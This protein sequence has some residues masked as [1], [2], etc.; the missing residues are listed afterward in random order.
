M[1]MESIFTTGTIPLA[2]AEGGHHGPSYWGLIFYIGLALLILLGL[3]AWAKK[4]F[5][6]RVFTNAPARLFEQLYLFI[7][8][9]CIG[10]IGERGK[11]YVPMMFVFWSVIFVSNVISLFFPTAPTADLGFNLGMALIAVGY[12]Q[13]EGIRQNGVIGHFAHFAGPK[14][15]LPMIVISL[16]IFLIEIISEVMKNVSLSLRLFGNINGGHAAV[17]AMN[18]L[19]EGY[20]IPIGA[21][22]L[23][24]KLLTCLV[25]ALIFTLLTCVYISLVTHDEHH[26]GEHD[27][28]AQPAAAH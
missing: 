5:S 23:P 14:L 20:Y 11:K 15:G 24:V 21:F 4:G 26:A 19:G 27:H 12:V 1:C 16:M 9:L 8:N 3:M 7:E 10:I 13:W 2:N 18:H 6:T 17:E 28:E 22:L 25:Q